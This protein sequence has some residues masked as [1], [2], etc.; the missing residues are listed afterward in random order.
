MDNRTYKYFRGEVLYPFG[1][2]LSYTQ[3]EYGDLQLPAKI[4]PGESIEVGVAVSNTG[5]LAGDEIVQLY[6]TN[7]GDNEASP[8][9]SLKRFARVSL[10]A[11]ESKTVSFNLTPKEYA[12]MQL[13][14]TILI[15]PG[16]L[17]V[18]VGG[19]QPGFI[20]NADAITTQVVS[21][22]ITVGGETLK[23]AMK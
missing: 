21:G 19:K 22:K 3:F 9:R 16:E 2:G 18:N 13:D 8:I 10:D 4:N 14:G 23:L 15:Q 6:I 11:G 5:A 1:H 17:T 7:S 20:G 12:S